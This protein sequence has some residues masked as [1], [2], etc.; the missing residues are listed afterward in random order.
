LAVYFSA[1][2]RRLGSWLL[3]LTD[4]LYFAGV[5][6]DIRPPQAAKFA[7]SGAAIECQAIQRCILRPGA[8]HGRQEHL[9]FLG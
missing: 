9:R 5:E 4:N 3:E 1:V 6:I 7:L 8:L 2:Q